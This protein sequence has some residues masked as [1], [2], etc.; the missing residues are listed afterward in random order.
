[1]CLHS[2]FP[3]YLCIYTDWI[4]IYNPAWNPIFKAKS[5]YKQA[6]VKPLKETWP[7]VYKVLNSQFERHFL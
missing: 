4:S 3:A 2:A 6:L 1:M 7:E 5:S